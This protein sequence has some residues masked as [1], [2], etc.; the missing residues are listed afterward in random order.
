MRIEPATARRHRQAV[1]GAETHRSVDAFTI[2]H[3]AHAGPTTEMRR[4]HPSR[5]GRI[6][7]QR[8]R[9]VVVGNSVIAPMPNLL[10]KHRRRQGVSLRNFRHCPMKRRIKHRYL[11]EPGIG[12]CQR[13]DGVQLV[14][15][16]RGHDW[17]ELFEFSEDFFPDEGRP[18]VSDPALHH[19]MANGDDLEARAVIL[20]PGDDEFE[21][22]VPVENAL[23]TPGLRVDKLAFCILR[24]EARL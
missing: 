16:V 7:R 8:A 13:A 9:D 2:E 20:K 24:S 19:A 23:P 4:D 14:W 22:S 10:A 12:F 21:G 15:L 11:G 18:M 1:D 5:R 6:A 3:G 17:Y